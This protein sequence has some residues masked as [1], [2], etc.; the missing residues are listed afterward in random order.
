MTLVLLCIIYFVFPSFYD[1]LAEHTKYYPEVLMT[2]Y[3][4]KMC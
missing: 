4:G 2:L 1:L 3:K